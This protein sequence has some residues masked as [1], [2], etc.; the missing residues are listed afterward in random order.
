MATITDGGF[1]NIPNL[2]A[3]MAPGGDFRPMAEVLSKSLDIVDDVPFVECNLELGHQISY[4]TGLP[5]PQWRSLNQ[6]V[7]NTKT[8]GAQFVEQT[9]MLEDR[10]EMDVDQPGDKAAF[11]RQEEAGKVEMMT[12]EFARAMFYESAANNAD[13]VHGLSARYGGTTGYTAS[14]YVQIGTNAGTNCQSIW[15][16]TW[17]P[18]KVYGIYPKGSK[19]GLFRQDLGE[20]DCFDSSSKKFRG[21]ATRL[22]WKFGFAVEDYRY[23]SRYQWDPDD[24]N[25]T[26]ASKGLYLG[27]LAQIGGLFKLDANTRFY[28]SR[29]SFNKLQAQLAANSTNYLEY[30]AMGGKRVPHF[31]GIPIR[32]TDALVAE[33]AL[34]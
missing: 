34:S 28:M 13:R 31:N 17:A 30:V 2:L 7:S 5:S 27:M 6:G 12:Q 20:I 19:I 22:Q 10:A 4:R 24:A 25:M 11:R 29:T 3:R 15:L 23:S 33:T 21:L 16:I 14:S 26:D 8:S 32:V 1:P 9:G 18:G